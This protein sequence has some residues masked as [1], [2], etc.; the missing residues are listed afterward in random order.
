MRRA[1]STAYF[2]QEEADPN[3]GRSV[4]ERYLRIR[5]RA[6]GLRGRSAVLHDGRGEALAARTDDTPRYRRRRSRVLVSAPR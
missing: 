4:L 3:D 5:Q 1:E 6:V 2:P